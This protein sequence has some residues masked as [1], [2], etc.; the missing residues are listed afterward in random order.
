MPQRRKTRPTHFAELVMDRPT[1]AEVA[2]LA[3]VDPSF[4]SKV[5]AGHRK[6][7]ERVRAAAE[8]V[9]GLPAEEIFPEWNPV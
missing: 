8:E 5:A 1:F 9:L 4:I 3:G 6:P 7:T 2:R